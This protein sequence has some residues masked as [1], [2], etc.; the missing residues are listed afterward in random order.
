MKPFFNI[1]LE[2]NKEII[3]HTIDDAIIGN[4]KGY[5]C[6]VD[7]NV[8]ATTCKNEEYQKIINSALINTCDGSSI[9]IFASL[10]HKK[11]YQT[12]TGPEIFAEYTQNKCKQHFIGNTNEN[13]NRLKI[14]F[15][16]L[17]YNTNLFQFEVLPFQ[18]VEEF[19]YKKIASRINEFQPNIIWVSLGAPK[20]EVFISKLYPYINQGVLFAIG[21]AFNFFL[22]DN[23]NQ[24]AP[25]WMRKI[26]LEWLYRVCKEPRRVGKRAVDY[27]ILLPK[28][29]IMEFKNKYYK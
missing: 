27:F 9:A 29:I 10:I 1:L 21:A 14:K 5:V 26:H 6:I 17:N 11:R 19:D 12:Y 20:Q 3:R 22:E 13:L 4:R 24:R 18:S 23:K 2:F 16:K 25:Q 28:L 8:L 7:G 15:Q